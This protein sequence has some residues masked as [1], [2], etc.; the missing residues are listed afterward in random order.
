M[1]PGVAL[2]ERFVQPCVGA[3]QEVLAVVGVDP[4]RVVVAVLLAAGTEVVEAVA[5]IACYV[6][7]H[8]HLVDEIGVHRRGLD[9]LVVVRSG[10]AGDVRAAL[11]PALAF[12]AGEVEAAFLVVGLDGGIHQIGVSRRYCQTDLAHVASWQAACDVPPGL[13]IVG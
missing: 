2:V 7:E 11:L 1:S 5:A 8:V 9:F 4:Q 10:P 13:A 3:G 6:Q 12:V